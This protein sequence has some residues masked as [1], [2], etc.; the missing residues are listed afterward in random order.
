MKDNEQV[1]E[2]IVRS[3]YGGDGSER[4]KQYHAEELSKVL[5][6]LNAQPDNEGV[7]AE[8]VIHEVLDS[9]MTTHENLPFGARTIIKDTITEYIN[10]KG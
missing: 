2:E 9:K 4:W 3:L 10:Q 8:E 6:I 1:A 7:S 5:I